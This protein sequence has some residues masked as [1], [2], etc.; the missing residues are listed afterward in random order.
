MLSIPLSLEMLRN[1]AAQ[2]R[3]LA[4]GVRDDQIRD[5]LL[6]LANEYDQMVEHHELRRDQP[7]APIDLAARLARRSKPL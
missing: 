1:R 2:C 3:H 5:R 6:Q 4:S 7:S